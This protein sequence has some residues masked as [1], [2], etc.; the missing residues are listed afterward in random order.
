MGHQAKR[1]RRASLSSARTDYR[2]IGC[3]WALVLLLPGLLFLFSAA[4]DA[5]GMGARKSW[6]ST[7]GTILSA[8][9]AADRRSR[10][11]KF[12]GYTVYRPEIRYSYTVAG[13]PYEGDVWRSHRTSLSSEQEA[14]QIVRGY[15]LRSPVTVYYDPLDPSRSYL[16]P[17][18]VGAD[19]FIR[20]AVGAGMIV[21]GLGVFFGVSGLGPRRR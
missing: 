14:A 19:E 8:A 2:R 17:E 1:R 21:G 6:R 18:R 13:Q 7:Q 15:P 20:M 4:R 16:V 9:Y 5:A 3:A 12:G 11:G 10:S